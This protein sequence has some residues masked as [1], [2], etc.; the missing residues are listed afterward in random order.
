MRQHGTE[1]REQDDIGGGHVERHAKNPLQRHIQRTDQTRDAVA[2]VRKEV[3]PERLQS[4]AEVA[5]EKEHDCSDRK[6]RT[7]SAAGGFQ[8]QEGCDHPQHQIKRARSR[9]SV[10]ELVEVND[11][12]TECDEHGER[13]RPVGQGHLASPLRAGRVAQEGQDQRDEK[14][15]DPVD[16][17]LYD[18]NHPVERID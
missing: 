14:K 3:K 12:P 13:Q 16:L 5:V 8:Y 11:G 18:A 2:P 4:G 10:D 17:W 7:D 6:D 1:D 9:C 15:A